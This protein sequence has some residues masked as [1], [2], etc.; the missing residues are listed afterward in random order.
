MTHETPPDAPGPHATNAPPP[1]EDS[2]RP[3]PPRLDAVALMRRL[4]ERLG[5]E[6]EGLSFDEQKRYLRERTPP[7]ASSSDASASKDA[8]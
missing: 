1:P 4:R 5:Q 7:R 8:A 6:M 3:A 2:A